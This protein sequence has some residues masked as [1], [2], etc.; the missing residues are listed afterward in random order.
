M[1]AFCTKMYRGQDIRKVGWQSTSKNT[2]L[3]WFCD[4]CIVSLLTSYWILCYDLLPHSKYSHSYL[5]LYPQA[6][7][8]KS[9]IFRFMDL[10]YWAIG[11]FSPVWL[12]RSLHLR[13]QLKCI[14]EA[15]L[16]FNRNRNVRVKTQQPQQPCLPL[17]WL[18]S[19]FT[20]GIHLQL[21]G[22][23]Q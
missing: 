11:Y 18:H 6:H 7:L 1:K 17:W 3:F 10:V 19:N 20:F 23:F 16:Q 9:W 15:Q 13:S 14:Y 5:I 21:G 22:L 2:L 8:L 12:L 4:V